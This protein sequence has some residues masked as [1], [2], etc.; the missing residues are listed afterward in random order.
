[1]TSYW[2]AVPKISDLIIINEALRK[3]ALFQHLYS[4]VTI[5]RQKQSYCFIVN[6]SISRILKKGKGHQGKLSQFFVS[7]STPKV[8]RSH[9]A[10]PLN[11]QAVS[12]YNNAFVH[13]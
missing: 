9:N 13:A 6:T 7:F 8:S 12:D 1:M 2:P 5:E 11:T 10:N 4:F 3:F